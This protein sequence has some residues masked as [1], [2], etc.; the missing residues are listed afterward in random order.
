MQKN[1]RITDAI[2]KQRTKRKVNKEY[3]LFRQGR[4]DPK[5]SPLPLLCFSFL[6][7]HVFKIGKTFNNGSINRAVSSCMDDKYRYEMQTMNVSSNK[8]IFSDV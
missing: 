4:E 7:L 2:F 1:T 6:E 3:T 8:I 5:I